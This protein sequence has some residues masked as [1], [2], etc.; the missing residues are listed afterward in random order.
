MRRNGATRIVI[1]TR[2]LAIKLPRFDSGWKA[3][4]VGLIANM[5][6]AE[7]GRLGWPELCPVRFSLPGGFLVVMPRARPLD[8][9]AWFALDY[10]RFF[11]SRGQV[12]LA[13]EKM[14]SFGIHD[15]R[16]VAVDYG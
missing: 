16:I 6:E 11:A 14:D 9:Q 8:R 10:R 1:L 2:R 7:F 12:A 13:E 5:Q 3:L 4:L 15:G